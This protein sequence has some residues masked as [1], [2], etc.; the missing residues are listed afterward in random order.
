MCCV[1]CVIGAEVDGKE[2]SGLTEMT[3]NA[4]YIITT[5]PNDAYGQGRSE[6]NH[7]TS[8]LSTQNVAINHPHAQSTLEMDSVDE[9]G[10]EFIQ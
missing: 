10:Y 1:L 2:E 8:L 3:Q 6:S 4:A 9:E 5:H 7:L